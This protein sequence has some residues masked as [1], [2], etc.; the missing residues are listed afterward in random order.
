MKTTDPVKEGGAVGESDVG[1]SEGRRVGAKLG[2]A[3]T[4]ETQN[5]KYQ[6]VS[7]KMKISLPSIEYS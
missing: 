5:V 1:V 7:V 3:V 6:N 2:T 4:Y